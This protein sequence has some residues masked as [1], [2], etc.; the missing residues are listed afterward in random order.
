MIKTS[1][2]DIET[3]S[4]IGGDI[5]K[6][7]QWLANIIKYQT[8]DADEALIARIE[9]GGEIQPPKIGSESFYGHFIAS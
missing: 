3:A 4:K 8:G 7:L 1:H 6:D 9:N 2:L 5:D